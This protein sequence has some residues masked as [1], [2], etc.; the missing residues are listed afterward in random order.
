MGIFFMGVVL[1]WFY[2]GF[3]FFGFMLLNMLMEG[4]FGVLFLWM[5]MLLVINNKCFVFLLNYD[6]ELLKNVYEEW[7]YG[8]LFFRLILFVWSNIFW[9]SI[10]WNIL[11]LILIF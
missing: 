4:L 5:E 11:F 6:N 1:F 3:M 7:G 9:L 8:W 2:L 10:F